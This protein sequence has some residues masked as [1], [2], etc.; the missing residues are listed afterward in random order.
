MQIV[1]FPCDIM[2]SPKDVKLVFVIADG[3]AVSNSWDFSF[4][5]Q[6]GKLVVSQIKGPKV[7]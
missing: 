6:L 3:M 5:F 1:Q 7:I 4:V 2:N